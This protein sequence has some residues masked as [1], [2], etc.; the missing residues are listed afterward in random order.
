MSDL[1]VQKFLRGGGTLADLATTYGIKAK[2][3]AA[4]GVVMLNYNQIA[5][6]MAETIC[7]ECRALLLE[8]GT[9][10]VVS[11]SFF[12]FFNL[13]EP[14]AHAVDWET[15]RV[16]EKLDGSLVCFYFH[17]E[18]WRV[19]TKGTPDASGPVNSHPITFAG[20]VKQALVEMGSSFEDLTER[21]DPAPGAG[22]DAG[23][24]GAPGGIPP[25]SRRGVRRAGV[26]TGP[27]RVRSAGSALPVLA[28][29]VLAARR[30]RHG[31]VLPAAAPGP[32]GGVAG[33]G[34]LPN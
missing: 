13:G 34:A 3:D 5:S 21:L 11:R 23:I 30:T 32:P 16:Q 20:L 33:H 24:A 26:G 1:E 19:A 8:T 27:A 10:N 18:R 12:K 2:A 22:R 7:Q 6:P 15:A 17:R 4:L 29:A 31:G 25:G 14:N 9:W 28:D